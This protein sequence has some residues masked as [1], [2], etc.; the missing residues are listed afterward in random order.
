M[1]YIL[2]CHVIKRLAAKVKAFNAKGLR[3]HVPICIRLHVD[4]VAASEP[5]RITWDF[6]CMMRAVSGASKIRDPFVRDVNH[7]LDK[8]MNQ[9]DAIASNADELW[10]LIESAIRT[11]VI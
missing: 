9:L 6:D 11:I 2:E 5:E 8:Q 7:A 4:Y 1:E 10:K 3:D